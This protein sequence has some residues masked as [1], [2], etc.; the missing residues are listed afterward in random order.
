[1]SDPIDSERFRH[2][3]P[4]EIRLVRNIYLDISHATWFDQGLKTEFAAYV[5]NMYQRGM[6]DPEKLKSLCSMAA[7][8]K[9]SVLKETVVT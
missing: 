1:M 7:R 4:E 3:A 9:F 6:V 5:I 8:R 2:L